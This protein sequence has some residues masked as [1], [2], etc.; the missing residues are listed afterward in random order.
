[1][2]KRTSRSNERILALLSL[3]RASRKLGES[4]NKGFVF[5]SLD[6]TWKD[7]TVL[8]EAEVSIVSCQTLLF[9]GTLETVQRGAWVEGTDLMC[10]CSPAKPWVVWRISKVPM[11]LISQGSL[12]N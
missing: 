6:V 9:T 1:M 5:A 11:C 10:S 3:A 4:C 7:S 12:A 2:A 8:R